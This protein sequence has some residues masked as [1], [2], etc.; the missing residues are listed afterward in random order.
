MKSQETNETCGAIGALL[1]GISWIAFVVVCPGLK[2]PGGDSMV[3]GF[4]AAMCVCCVLACALGWRSR[5]SFWIWVLSI[6][7]LILI[8]TA[9]A[10]IR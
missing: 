6:P 2:H 9:I 3:A 10:L 5:S 8:P 7:N 1:T 4:I